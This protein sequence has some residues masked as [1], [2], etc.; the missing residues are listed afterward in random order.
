MKSPEKRMNKSPH[1]VFIAV[2]NILLLLAPTVSLSG[3]GGALASDWGYIS[4]R[5]SAIYQPGG[6]EQFE[7]DYKLSEGHALPSQAESVPAAQAQPLSEGE[8]NQILQTLPPLAKAQLASFSMPVRSLPPPSS[9]RQVDLTFPPPQKVPASLAPKVPALR[10]VNKRPEGKVAKAGELDVTFSQPMVEINTHS[11]LSKVPVPV[12]LTPLPEGEWQWA[13]TQTVSFVPTKRHFPMATEYTVT[14]PAATKSINGATLSEP[15]SWK[16]TT[17]SPQLIGH[18]P[19][20]TRS[21]R[22]TTLMMMHFN[23]RVSAS[24]ILALT[25][26]KAGDQTIPIA[27]ASEGDISEDTTLSKRI[28][29]LPASSTVTFKTVQPLPYNSRIVIHIGPNIPSAEGPRTTASPARFEFHTY[30]PLRLEAQSADS[31]KVMLGQP[32]QLPFTNNIDAKTF[33]DAFVK[34]TP[35]FK[36]ATRTYGRYIHVYGA[37]KAKTHYTVEIS[38][39]LKDE[40][41]QQLTGDNT[42]GFDVYSQGSW[43]RMPDALQVVPVGYPAKVRVTSTNVPS[44]R[45]KVY[46]VEPEMFGKFMDD[47]S[48]PPVGASLV[49]NKEI[50]SKGGSD[51]L[52]YTNLDL[53]SWMKKKTGHLLVM[54]TGLTKPEKERQTQACWVESTGIGLDTYQ[55]QDSAMAWVT[56]INTGAPISGATIASKSMTA[57]GLSDENGIAR[58]IKR[59]NLNQENNWDIIIARKNGDSSLVYLSSYGYYNENSNETFRWYTISDRSP[60][61]PGETA[62]IKGLIRKTSSGTSAALTN[63]FTDTKGVHYTVNDSQGNELSK[64]TA[65]LNRFGAFDFSVKLPK[66][67]NLGSA[68]VTIQ[69]DNISSNG[70]VSLNVAEFRRPEFKLKIKNEDSPISIIK[71]STLMSAEASYYA[72]GA[73]SDSEV[74]WT[75]TSAATRYS[76]PGW[77]EFTFGHAI[78]IFDWFYRRLPSITPDWHPLPPQ[79]LKGVTDADG[80]HYLRIDWDG[81]KPIEPGQLTL[82]ATVQD[83]NR[84]TWSDT[85][86]LTV[87]PSSLYVGVHQENSFAKKGQTMP[88]SF[89]VTDI[90]GKAVADKKFNIEIWR[91]VTDPSGVETTEKADLK[92]FDPTSSI[93]PVSLEYQPQKGG[94][95][96]VVATVVDSEGRKNET[97]SEFLVEG[98]DLK[99][100][101]ELKIKT[102]QLVSQKSKYKPG[103]TASI[104]V[105]SPFAPANGLA[106]IW[107][108]GLARKVSFTMK[109][110]SQ[111]IEIP[112]IEDDLPSVVVQVDVVGSETIPPSK[113]AVPAEA[114]GTVT[115]EVSTDSRRLAVT[116]KPS[117]E[118]LEP[119]KEVSI[120]VAVVDSSG[121][122]AAGSEVTVAVV[123]QSLLSLS[124]YSYPDPIPTFYP[125][126]DSWHQNLRAREHIDVNQLLETIELSMDQQ[127]PG[128]AGGA[129]SGK[130]QTRGYAMGNIGAFGADASVMMEASGGIAPQAPAP[131]MMRAKMK[132]ESKESGPM[133]QGATNGTIGPTTLDSFVMQSGQPLPQV[134]VRSNFDALANWSPNV[135]TDANGHAVI[136]FKL[137]DNLTQYRIMAVASAGSEKFGFGES[138]LTARLPVMAKPSAPRF[139]NFGDKFELPIVVQNQ[140]DKPLE[141]RLAARASNAKFTAGQGRRFI[142]PAN[143]RVEVRLP[144]ETEG[145][146]EASFQVVAIAG[147][148]SDAATFSLPVYT[149]ATTE[150]FATYGQIDENHGSVLQKIGTPPDVIPGFGALEV[151]TSSTAL[152]NLTDAFIYLQHYPFECSEQLASRI[153]SIALMKDMLKAFHAAGVPSEAA[154]KTALSTDMKLLASRQRSNG[155]FGLWKLDDKDDYPYV[156]LHVTH[157]LLRSRQ[158]DFEVPQQMLDRALNYVKTIDSHI[159]SDY[160][161]S[162][163]LEL[164]AFA[165][166]LRAVNGEKNPALARKLLATQPMDQM[167][168]ETLALILNAI[169]NDPSM[170]KE[171]ESIRQFFNNSIVESSGTAQLV[172]RKSSSDYRMFDSPTRSN[173]ILLDALIKNDKDRP[174]ITKLLK[175]LLGGRVRGHWGTTQENAYVL[176]A[177]RHYFDKYENMT[178]DFVAR[179][180]LGNDFAGESTFKGRSNEFKTIKVPMSYLLKEPATKDLVVEKRGAGRLYYRLGL[181]YAPKNLVLAELDRGFAV[182]RSYEFV[183]DKSDVSKDAQGRWH[184]K[185]GSLVRVKLKMNTPMARSFVALVDPLAAG[186]EAL[187]EDLKGTETVIGDETQN[188][189]IPYFW[190]RWT[191]WT[192]QNKRDNQVEVFANY[193]SDGNYD[194]SYLVRATTPGTFVVPPTKAEEMYAPETFGRAHSEIVVVE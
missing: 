126:P 183:E 52:A 41:G 119:G 76:P 140:T 103:E 77:T 21:V 135:V 118:A 159:P 133:L 45:V 190:W 64:G 137:P 188:K 114:S 38:R 33:K 107:H 163:R 156:T 85:T 68:N 179:V 157:A 166:Y 153:I 4:R 177:M 122:P 46:S 20:V 62:H 27:Q 144:V 47:Q 127:T 97:I 37:P 63:A 155:S 128:S 129:M 120:D 186:V 130:G 176:V 84:Q 193:L 123:D 74:N 16:F 53:S 131:M 112:I 29:N 150:A 194:Y 14:I 55:H 23:Q 82:Q 25:T 175:T 121:K 50:A 108:N 61:R 24:A 60:Y 134:Q 152:Q 181:N 165:L 161:Q 58:L 66:E 42:A 6:G 109:E 100:P 185:A 151:T 102:L 26:V 3:S 146:G 172:D 182:E 105:Q 28:K 7:L 19:E 65:P 125:T 187:N 18:Y 31:K 170:D 136:R 158:A 72:G 191:W 98:A 167:R 116:A 35:S 9:A 69:A 173:A 180:W 132:G 78:R 154:I 5:D 67:M 75:A 2:L 83:V 138:S 111:S 81:M 90:E 171:A 1:I 95:H 149:P 96:R 169:S 117:S 94:M 51:E 115:L 174:L 80:K 93:K 56:D 71:S 54:V 44:F 113:G 39:E 184:F 12:T 148:N 141:V 22:P 160:S 11:A 79:R 13:G 8:T 59:S 104:L 32:L 36:F 10:V 17:P 99:Q 92:T 192:H 48:K 139:L 168:T 147:S 88:F 86:T 70:N 73:L 15:V 30:G 91:I 164:Q 40:F 34:V 162:A 110:T 89:I 142:A 145:A 101:S 124:G 49:S 143:N 57:S 106:T 178:P 87:H 189:P 43:F